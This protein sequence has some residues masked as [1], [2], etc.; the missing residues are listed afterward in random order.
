M[1]QLDEQEKVEALRRRLYARGEVGAKIEE[2]GVSDIK[3]DVSRDW[4]MPSPLEIPTAS[5]TPKP[6]RRYRWYVL[7]GSLSALLLTVAVTGFYMFSG[8][9]QISSDNINLNIEAPRTLGGGERFDAQIGIT[10]QNAVAIE[11]ATLIVTYPANSQTVTEPLESLFE[12]RIWIDRLDPG[13]VKNVPIS[14]LVYGE[15]GDERRF[16]AQLEYR[17]IDSDSL[18]YKDAEPHNFRITSSPVTLQVESVRRVSAGQA[19]EVDIT[20]N[21]NTN[22]TYNNL[23]VTASYPRGFSFQGAE[24]EPSEGKRGAAKRDARSRHRAVRPDP[25]AAVHQKSPG[26]QHGRGGDPSRRRH[27]DPEAREAVVIRRRS[28]GG[29]RRV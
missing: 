6:S 4:Q 18:F 19:V 25:N 26:E 22:T 23:L 13:E 5:A 12:E 27:N 7:L 1:S 28:R 21:S 29:A 14:A 9:N 17:I 11:S 16:Q 24:P 3:V 20:V 2:H 15:E 10:N 8:G